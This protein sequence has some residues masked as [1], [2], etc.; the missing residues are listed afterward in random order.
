VCSLGFEQREKREEGRGVLTEASYQRGEGRA[1][2][3]A[4]PPEH[5]RRRGESR[6]RG[7]ITRDREEQR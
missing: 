3:G 5:G 6:W 7:G 4:E 2:A 1:P